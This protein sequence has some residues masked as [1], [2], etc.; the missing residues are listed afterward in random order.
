VRL[1]VDD[2][3]ACFRFLK[4]SLGLECTFGGEDDGYAGFTG[5]EG[6][7][8]VIPRDDRRG[9]V[10]LQAAGWGAL[11]VLAA[12]DLETEAA[13]LRDVVVGGPVAKAAWGG[14][15]VYLRDSDGDQLELQQ[16]TQ[17]GE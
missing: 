16:A 2:F 9:V 8:A 6:A 15:V 10:E 7:R 13:R 17:T 14:H 11:T 1:L 3:P 5:G 4:D 12:D